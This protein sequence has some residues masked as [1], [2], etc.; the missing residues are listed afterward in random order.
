[1]ENSLKFTALLVFMSISSLSMFSKNKLRLKAMAAKQMNIRI[2]A[3]VV[4]M[5]SIYSI[6]ALA[7]WKMYTNRETTDH[8]KNKKPKSTLLLNAYLLCD[9]SGELMPKVA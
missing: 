7:T 5:L 1:M 6:N 2:F 4:Q 9:G 3:E 8:P